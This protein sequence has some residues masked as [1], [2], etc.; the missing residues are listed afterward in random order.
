MASASITERQGPARI[1][2]NT[3]V[4]GAFLGA[5]HIYQNMRKGEIA[6][7]KLRELDASEIGHYV[8]LSNMYVVDEKWGD[9]AEVRKLVEEKQL[10]KVSGHSIVE[11]RDEVC[12]FVA[13]DKSHQE[14]KQIYELLIT[15]QGM[16][17]EEYD[18]FTT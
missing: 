8:L 17:K 1:S 3:N 13:N 10:K 4:W 16:M 9:V 11:V 2:P 14:S 18:D 7:K 6:T 12:T 15:F 5:C